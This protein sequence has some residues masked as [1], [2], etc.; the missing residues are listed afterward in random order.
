[1]EEVENLIKSIEKYT[2]ASHLVWGLWGIISVGFLT[3]IPS[4]VLPVNPNTLSDIHSKLNPLAAGPCQWY[5]LRLQGIREAK[6]RAVLAE[7]TKYPNFSDCWINPGNQ[8]LH[9]WPLLHIAS[10]VLSIDAFRLEGC[11]WDTRLWRKAEPQRPGQ[12]RQSGLYSFA[13]LAVHSTRRQAS[14]QPWLLVV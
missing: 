9:L 1:M 2:L 3:Q 11:P 4:H 7:E 12:A 8:F 6:V 14:I 13:S 10:P 5:R